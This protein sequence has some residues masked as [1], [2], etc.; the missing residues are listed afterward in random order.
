MNPAELTDTL[1]R[2]L[3]ELVTLVEALKHGT[4]SFE[5]QQSA[6]ALRTLRARF[7]KEGQ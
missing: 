6:R 5:V 7:R 3:D 2:T 1:H 4:T